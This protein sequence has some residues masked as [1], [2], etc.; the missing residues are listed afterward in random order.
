MAGQNTKTQGA[1][2]GDS[3]DGKR[4]PKLSDLPRL[5]E[6]LVGLAS[7]EKQADR[8]ATTEQLMKALKREIMGALNKGYTM[9]D[10]H[11]YLTGE[12][13]DLSLSTLRQ[14]WAKVGSKRRKASEQTSEQSGVTES[15]KTESVALQPAAKAETKKATAAKQTVDTAKAASVPAVKQPA[16]KQKS[17]SETEVAPAGRRLVD[18]D[19]SDL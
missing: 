3:T 1:N 5:R 19:S 12:G 2:V 10:I 17:E 8:D 9:E 15:P 6:G 11:R 16:D 7:A 4:R 13:F 14:T 18:H